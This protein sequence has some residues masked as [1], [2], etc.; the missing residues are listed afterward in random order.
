[1]TPASMKPR[2]THSE[3]SASRGA[4]LEF[5]AVFGTDLRRSDRF[6]RHFVNALSAIRARGVN[7]AVT[8]MDSETGSRRV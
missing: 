2:T 5:T 7:A 6:V 4:F 8:A 3:L 1:M